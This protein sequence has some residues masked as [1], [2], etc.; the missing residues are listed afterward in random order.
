MAKTTC[1]LTEVDSGK[2]ISLS[3]GEQFELAL[4]GNPTTGYQWEIQSYDAGLIS[5]VDNPGFAQ[6]TS[7]VGA[8]GVFKFTFQA[9]APGNT[10]LKLVYHRP[11]EKK[12]KPLRKFSIAVNIGEE[13]ANRRQKE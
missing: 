10:P 7:L 6:S 13:D 9:T 8:G 2:T 4:Y 1:V 5:P 12:A 3:P 11:F